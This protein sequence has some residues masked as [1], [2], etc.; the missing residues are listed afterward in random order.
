MLCF[1]AIVT[2]SFTCPRFHPHTYPC[3]TPNRFLDCPSHTEEPVTSRRKS[4]RR[5][6]GTHLQQQADHSFFSQADQVH[7]R[8]Q[9]IQEPPPLPPARPT[10]LP[11]PSIRGR[12]DHIQAPPSTPKIF[13]FIHPASSLARKATTRATSMGRPTLCMGDH[14]LAYSSTSSSLRVV[15]LGLGGFVSARSGMLVVGGRVRMAVWVVGGDA[16]WVCR[17]R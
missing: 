14:V 8:I 3:C 11:H 2:L 10:D 12:K 9:A 1:A 15:P 4:R 17:M 16:V 6:Y 7:L 13:P 5:G